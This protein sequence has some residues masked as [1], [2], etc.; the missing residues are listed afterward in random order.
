MGRENTT[1]DGGKESGAPHEVAVVGV[2]ERL[3][4]CLAAM[5]IDGAYENAAGEGGNERGAP[6]LV[7]VIGVGG[8]S[9]NIRQARSGEGRRDM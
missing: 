1:G 7:A 4:M 2:M 9:S 5:S 6:Q 3:D 8:T